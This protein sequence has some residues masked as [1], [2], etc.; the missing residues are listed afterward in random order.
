MTGARTRNETPCHPNPAASALPPAN[1]CRDDRPTRR[2]G[3]LAAAQLLPLVYDKLRKRA[4]QRLTEEQPGQTLDTT[5]LVHEAHLRLAGKSAFF[6]TTAEA[7]RRILIKRTS[8]QR[9]QKTGGVRR[10]LSG[11]L[12]LPRAVLARIF[13]APLPCLG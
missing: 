8:T 3:P 1:T 2:A 11:S 10:Q 4:D 12:A 5:A 9:S 6:A 7:M 13:L